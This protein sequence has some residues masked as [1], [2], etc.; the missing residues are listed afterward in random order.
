MT[1]RTAVRSTLRLLALSLAAMAASAD[2]TGNIDIGAHYGTMLGS[3]VPANDMPGYRIYGLYYLNDR[4]AL[5]I[6][7]DR[8]K[9]DYEEPARR[10]GLPID[11]DAEPIDAK[12]EADIVSAFVQRAIAKSERREWFVGAGGAIV[13]TD[14]PDITGPTATGGTFDIRTEV[15]R[16]LIASLFGG[17]RQRFGE[18]WFLQFTLRADQHFAAWEPE[19]RVSGA[20]G[21]HDDYFAYGGH[22]GIG[23]RF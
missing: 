19:D 11:P 12:A 17:V 16:E 14:V 5:G 7:F 20:M 18:R 2:E 13:F 4:W 15:D 21:R 3:G 8:S 1:C 23:Y 6:G 10:L 9:F 22:L